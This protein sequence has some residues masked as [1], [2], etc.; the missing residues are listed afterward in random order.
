[1]NHCVE[2]KFDL[3][4]EVN[5][6]LTD[7]AK[8]ECC[9]RICVTGAELNVL[10]RH[11]LAQAIRDCSNSKRMDGQAFGKSSSYHH[12]RTSTLAPSFTPSIIA[13]ES[14]TRCSL[15]V[16]CG[17]TIAMSVIEG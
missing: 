6:N 11:L 4:F 1:M 5:C 7:V 16:R 3:A 2:V 15:S 12:Q 13:A 8:F 9:P 10:K 14:E 17:S